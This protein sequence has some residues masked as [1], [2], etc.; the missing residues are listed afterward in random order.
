VGTGVLECQ[1]FVLFLELPFLKES[2]FQDAIFKEFSQKTIEKST[3]I[4]A[5]KK[6]SFSRLFY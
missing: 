2:F 3:P 1:D 5:S 4:P 6:N